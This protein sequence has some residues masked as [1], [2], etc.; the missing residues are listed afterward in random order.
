MLRE[1]TGGVLTDSGGLYG[2]MYQRP[3]PSKA[4]YPVKLDGKVD[5]HQVS[6]AH[7][8]TANTEYSAKLTRSLWRFSSSP[9]WERVPWENVLEAWAEKRNLE[10]R[11]YG[12]TYNFETSLDQDF[13]AWEWE[14]AETGEHFAIIRSHNGCDARWGFSK[15]RIFRCLGESDGLEY[16][17]K[18]DYY[19]P[20]CQDE[21]EPSE[22][23]LNDDGC[24]C[25][26]CGRQAYVDCMGLY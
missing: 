14:D 26:R 21:C 9:K 24:I 3:I 2:Y 8:L 4:I 22:D 25:E 10:I 11:E 12:Y 5:W 19:C 7:W 13:A 18:V 6:L 16:E 1:N 17:T 23:T 15:P 20:E